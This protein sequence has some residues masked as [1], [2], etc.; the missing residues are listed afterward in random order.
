MFANRHIVC[1][2]LSVLLWMP[3]S[4][5]MAQQYQKKKL[6]H[7]INLS[8]GGG[9]D[10]DVSRSEMVRTG[11]GGGGLFAASYEVR[12][13]GFFFNVGLGADYRAMNY[14]V[15]DMT[16][17]F[18]SQ[19]PD[20]HPIS[21]RY[22][23][24]D[25]SETQHTLYATLPIQLGYIIQDRVYIA[26]GVKAALP[27]WNTYSAKTQMYTEGIYAN[28]IDPISQ[29]VPA[30]AF[31]PQASYAGKGS[32]KTPLVYVSPSVEAGAV[33]ELAEKISCRLGG[34]VE[35]NLPVGGQCPH[36][37]IVRYAAVDMNPRTRSLDNLKSGLAFG[38]VLNGMMNVSAT[39]HA[40][41]NLFNGWNQYLRIGV[42]AT[43]SFNVTK[44]KPVCKC[45][46]LYY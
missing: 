31:Y 23:Y 15:N 13:N 1:I 8:V 22:V 16:H 44:Y 35:F 14:K 3:F 27:V 32:Y 29:D 24:S 30:F 41:Q 40:G 21:Y 6:Q 26:A 33:F 45:L 5:T 43:F 4:P 7:H 18:D 17:A 25:Y 10:I 12:D 46:G 37:E 19:D 39:E 38:S 28:L 20:G 34:F 2:V 42:R 36:E 9:M 11:L